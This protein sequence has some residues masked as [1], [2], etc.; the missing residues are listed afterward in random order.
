MGVPQV[1]LCEDGDRITLDGGEAQREPDAAPS[2]HVYVDGLE[3]GDTVGGI[4][5]DRRHL[6]ED[7][8][9][10][11]TLAIDGRTGE[12]VQGPDLE[13]HGFMD[14]P[15]AVFAKARSAVRSEV[16]AVWPSDFDVLRRHVRTVVNRVIRAETARRAVVIPVLIE[17]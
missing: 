5:R 4:I 11:V 15:E 3:V 6:A 1:F 7:G 16:D 17:I 9:V 14:D 2:G 13:S 12:V 10:V 8:V